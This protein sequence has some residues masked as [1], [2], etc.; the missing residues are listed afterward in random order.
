MMKAITVSDQKK[1][2][3]EILD[4]I[5][6]FCRSNHIRYYLLGGTLIGAV[7]HK[8][9][10]P[11]D[12][13][14][15]I[16]MLREDYE[17]FLSCYNDRNGRYKLISQRTESRYHLPMA[18]VFDTRTKLEESVSN[19]CPI[20]IYVDIF[21]IDNCPGNYE[22]SCKF[23]KKIGVYRNILSLKNIKA[24]RGRAFYKNLVLILGKVICCAIPRKLIIRKIDSIAGKYRN[25]ESIEYV[26]EL[27]LNPYG[28]QEIYKK[29]WFDDVSELEF[30]GK[31]YYAPCG[32]DNVLKTCFGNYMVLP[33]E[34][35][36]ITHHN[37]QVWWNEL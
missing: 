16:C 13:D 35:D 33:P 14:I 4:E 22:E 36:R 3:I 15:D 31:K 34:E 23:V 7:R 25:I 24:S 1:I 11:W 26:G 2:L 28:I 5:D 10:I 27:V 21:P 29:E 30:E 12:D 8:G 9:F 32:Y 18:K 19:G 6:T 37:N 17:R 20:G